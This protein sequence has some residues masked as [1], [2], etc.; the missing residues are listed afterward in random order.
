MTGV[1]EGAGIT[2]RTLEVLK[3]LPLWLFIG[4]AVACGLLLFFPAIAISVPA[5]A[6]PWIDLAGVVFGVLALARAI[7]ALVEKIPVWKA[8]ADKRRKFHIT[9]EPQQSHWSSSKQPDD[10]VVT[11]AVMRCVIKNRTEEPLGLVR[12]RLISPKIRGEVVHEGV[13]VRGVNRDVYG[14]AAHSGHVIPAGMLLPG[15]VDIMIRGVTRRKLGRQVRAI[16]GVMDDEGYGQK[17]AV[18]MQ[19]SPP[20]QVVAAIPAIE[21]VSSIS[22]PIEREVASVLQA[23]LSRYDKCGRRV[24]GLGSVHLVV[25]GQ[26]STGVGTDAWNPNS[27]RNQSISENPDSAELRSDN[28]EALTTFYNRLTTVEEKGHFTTALLDRMD[29]GGYLKVTYF[30]VCALWKIG[31][32]REALEKAKSVLPQG[33]MKAFGVSNTLMLLNGLLRYRYPDF[34]NEMLDDIEKFLIGLKEHP[35]QI[36]EKIAVI[37]TAR[38]MRPQE[39]K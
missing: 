27:P 39:R 19:V 1:G 18:N 26:P 38:L 23:E 35:F 32:L 7:G 4:L 34:T 33:E 6:H 12:A 24:G 10:S 29:G 25:N 21:V 15:S 36:P 11:Q 17:V 28:L 31:K 20:P 9:P 13:L 16:I 8:S 5:V 14:S 3:D 30:I 22:D 2:T 37:R